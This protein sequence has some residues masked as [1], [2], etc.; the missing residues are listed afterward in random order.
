MVET[1]ALV[2]GVVAHVL[3]ILP[4]QAQARVRSGHPEAGEALPF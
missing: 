3:T 4:P 2:E 1:L